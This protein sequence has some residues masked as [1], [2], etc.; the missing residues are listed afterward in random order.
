[1]GVFMALIVAVIAGLQ[2][3]DSYGTQIWTMNYM[4]W[5]LIVG[6]IMGDPLTGVKIGATVQLCL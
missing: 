4:I 5:S 2:L 3:V 1:M 6:I